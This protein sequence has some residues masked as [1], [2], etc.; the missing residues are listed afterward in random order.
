MTGMETSM[1]PMRAG[2]PTASAV[3]AIA[4]LVGCGAAVQG[5]ELNYYGSNNWWQSQ[6]KGDDGAA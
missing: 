5:R 2:A 3:L 4:L 1:G 6:P